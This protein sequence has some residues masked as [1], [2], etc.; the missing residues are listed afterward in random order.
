[1]VA[2]PPQLNVISPL[3]LFMAAPSVNML[4][5]GPTTP[6][7][8]EGRTWASMIRQRSEVRV[9]VRAVEVAGLIEI[10]RARVVV[11]QVEVVRAERA[12]TAGGIVAVAA[13]RAVGHHAVLQ[14]DGLGQ[15]KAIIPNP[16]PGG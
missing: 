2:G 11:G 12:P 9:I 7:A 8:C 5:G 4:Q 16:T 14:R 13:C 3:P 6:A 15:Q 1:M 10:R